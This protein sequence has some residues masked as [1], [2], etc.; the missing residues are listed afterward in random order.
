MCQTR[1]AP[2]VNFLDQWISLLAVNI[3]K[4]SLRIISLLMRSMEI[5][6]ILEVRSGPLNARKRTWLSPL[7]KRGPA[8]MTRVSMK[9]NQLVVNH[10]PLMRF[11]KVRS[12]QVT[13]PCLSISRS[14]I[15]LLSKR[16]RCSTSGV[17]YF[18]TKMRSR[19]RCSETRWRNNVS[20][21]LL[22]RPIL[23]SSARR[24]RKSLLRAE[25]V[26]DQ[27]RKI[28]Y[29]FRP[30]NNSNVSWQTRRSALR[31]ATRS[32]WR[33]KSPSMKRREYANKANWMTKLIVMLPGGASSTMSNRRLNTRTK[34]VR[35][36]T[37]T[38]VAMRR[39]CNVSN[40]NVRIRSCRL[41]SRTKYLLNKRPRSSTK[42]IKFVLSTSW[43]WRTSS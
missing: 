20:Y 3:C 28:C 36:K 31:S 24:E 29:V 7:L 38:N 9:H 17:P 42:M 32:V 41:S 40:L 21:N 5:L 10:L 34:S 14:V 16:K 18:A 25:Y 4:A 30:S 37:S 2:A 6:K 27:K 19:T 22:S 39:F 23:I 1:V 43:R 11:S 13:S 35:D 15:C 12:K 26:R 33:P 8:S